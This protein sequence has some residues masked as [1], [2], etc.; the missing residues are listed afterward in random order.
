MPTHPF[1]PYSTF[2]NWLANER[3][4]KAFCLSNQPKFSQKN[5][6]GIAKLLSIFSPL[7]QLF[8]II[9]SITIASI[10]EGH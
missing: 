7:F 5:F 10:A 6:P 2:S 1:A 8:I 9:V 3:I 4:T